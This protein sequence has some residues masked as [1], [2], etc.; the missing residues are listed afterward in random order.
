MRLPG[1]PSRRGT[2]PEHSA[3]KALLAYNAWRLLLLV[4]CL[5]IGDLA[6]LHGFP[7]IVVALLVSGVLSW[8]LL[9]RQRIN[10]GM[11]VESQ[12]Q[13]G[14]SKLAERTARE[15]AYADALAAQQAQQAAG[16]EAP[17]HTEQEPAVAEVPVSPP[18]RDAS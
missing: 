14:R 17:G 3:S 11:A 1:V 6:G 13:R 16:A 7:L 10:M 5:G 8:F 9:K 18:S 4:A 12:V 2:P 15:D